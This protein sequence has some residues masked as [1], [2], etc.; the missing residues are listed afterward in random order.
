MQLGLDRSL[1]TLD[2]TVKQAFEQVLTLQS[3]QSQHLQLQLDVL[4][5]LFLH[6]S[7]QTR[8]ILAMNESS[9]QIDEFNDSLHNNPEIHVIRLPGQHQ[10]ANM[11]QSYIAT[12]MSAA[13][14]VSNASPLQ[15]KTPPAWTLSSH[16]TAP[17]VGLSDGK[18][19]KKSRSY[20]VNRPLQSSGDPVAHNPPP[21]A[22]TFSTQFAARLWSSLLLL[23]FALQDCKEAGDI[24]AK[25]Q[26]HVG[27][28]KLLRFVRGHALSLSV[29]QTVQRGMPPSEGQI[30]AAILCLCCS[31]VSGDGSFKQLLG[32]AGTP[33]ISG[34]AL[35]QQ[36]SSG[37]SG[38]SVNQLL[39]AGLCRGLHCSVRWLSLRL[40]GSL[41]GCQSAVLAP[42]ARAAMASSTAEALQGSVQEWQDM[43]VSRGRA[44]VVQRQE[45]AHL[46]LVLSDLLQGPH[47]A[48]QA[49]GMLTQESQ[50]TLPQLLLACLDPPHGEAML[51]LA[52]ARLAAA[53][54]LADRD[55]S[56]VMN[57]L[58]AT[59][60]LAHSPLAPLLA[61]LAGSPRT[62]LP[63]R[64]S[65]L[66][67][68]WCMTHHSE[69]AKS[70]FKQVL[71]EQ[72]SPLL[73]GDGDEGQDD[74]EPGEGEQ[75]QCRAAQRAA[76]CL[77]LLLTS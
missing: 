60:C 39:T 43:S 3:L 32:L 17:I 40:L 70:L 74:E 53:L 23:I 45:T 1:C 19:R 72:D 27:L 63:V 34:S 46:L 49:Y 21:A 64:H 65:A 73:S 8:S 12:V 30:S 48:A 50:P 51:Q 61:T 52:V 44:R 11:L 14:I 57:R 77:R 10:P 56:K 67:A 28:N 59:S 76:R 35:T 25:L 31:F 29:A 4:I 47:G 41:A 69:R 33:A 6:H 37:A 68:V 42:A 22:A 24:A 38:V 66:M 16:K 5:A 9:L 54:S 15:A 71:S 2:D 26:L 7:R 75:G 55:G 36:D 20:R 58:A 62:A 18:W 13:D